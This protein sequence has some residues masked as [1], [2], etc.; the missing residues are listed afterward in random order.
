MTVAEQIAAERKRQIAEDPWSR[1]YF[2]SGGQNQFHAKE[3]Y[4]ELQRAQD[5]GEKG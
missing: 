1:V 4:V 2:N 3:S 5:K